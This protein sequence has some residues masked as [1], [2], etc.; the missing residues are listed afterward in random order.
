MQQH[1]AH[2][3]PQLQPGQFELASRLR[4]RKREDRLTDRVEPDIA[5]DCVPSGEVCVFG[6]PV[7]DGA[8]GDAARLS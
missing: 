2:A 8:S 3:D 6:D 5:S 1:H 7:V 4:V